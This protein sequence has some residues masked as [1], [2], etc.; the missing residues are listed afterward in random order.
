MGLQESK[1]VNPSVR[2]LKSIW[3]G[4]LTKWLV[5]DVIVTAGGVVVEVE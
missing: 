2:I 5:L 4:R 3:G 1:L